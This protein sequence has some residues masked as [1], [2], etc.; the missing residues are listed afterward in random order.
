MY[1]PRLPLILLT[2][3]AVL[4]GGGWLADS[5]AASRVERH[6]S[7]AVEKQS[8]LEVSPRVNVGGVPYLA[9]LVTGEIPTVSVHALDVDVAGLGMVNAQT[10]L[11]KIT[12]TREQVLSGEIAGSP[13]SSFTRTIRLDGVALGRLLGITDLDI[14][15][16]YDISP[17]GGAAAEAQLTGTPFNR[18]EPSTVIVDLRLVGDEFHMTPRE[19]IDAPADLSPAEADA[20]RAAFAFTLNTRTLPLAGRASRVNMSGGSIFFEAERHNVTVRLA[21]LSPV[22]AS[23]TG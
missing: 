14:A 6:I 23:G 19:L 8:G 1:V 16:P 4:F 12:V 13:A 21:D 18:R 9:A 22:D 2:V 11:N 7:A 20:I 5:I 10:E 15:N 17:A 3:L